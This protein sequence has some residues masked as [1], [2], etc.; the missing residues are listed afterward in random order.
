VEAEPT[1]ITG[2]LRLAAFGDR[3]FDRLFAVRSRDMHEI[4]VRLDRPKRR[5]IASFFEWTDSRWTI[6]KGH[7]NAEFRILEASSSQI[8][9]TVTTQL[10]KLVT[11]P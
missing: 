11:G 1:T 4:Q 5:A 8:V 10:A 6:H 3:E 2:P 9:D 7:V